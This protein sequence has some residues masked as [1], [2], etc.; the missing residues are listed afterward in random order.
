MR[1]IVAAT[2]VL[3][4]LA[5]VG[6]VLALRWYRGEQNEPL[7]EKRGSSTVEFVPEPPPPKRPAKFV[8]NEPWPLYGYNAARTRFAPEFRHRP[9]YRAVWS[10]RS[11]NVLEFPP[12]VVYS[13]VI[14][15][16]Q[17]GRVFALRAS[18]GKV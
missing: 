1:R 15:A 14:F 16:Q 17:R 12:V 2:L 8:R 11:G 13:R 4:L 7:P 6:G 9:P 10:F 18:N 3:A 5:A